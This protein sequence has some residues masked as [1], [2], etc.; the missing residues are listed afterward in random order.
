M[1]LSELELDALVE[2]FNLGVGQAAHSLSQIAGE[3]VY[4]SVPRV[5]MATRSGMAEQLQAMGCERLCAVHQG[6]TGVM[7]TE[8]MLMFPIDQSLLLVQMMV[9]ESAP[10]EQLGE[11]E[12]D[13]IA[14]VGNILL[15]GIVGSMA[16]VLHIKFEGTLPRVEQGSAVDVLKAHGGNVEQILNLEVDFEIASREIH[17]FIDFM[18]DVQSVDLLKTHLE[19]FIAGASM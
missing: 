7:A 13:A 14:E 12:Q 3:T 18:L 6:F 10:L 8:A 19:G 1:N 4:L 2:I 16:N 5:S 11:M 9:G 15:N 17:G